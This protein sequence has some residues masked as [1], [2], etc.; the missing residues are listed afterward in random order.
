MNAFLQLLDKMKDMDIVKFFSRFFTQATLSPWLHRLQ[1]A[2]AG[3]DYS[4]SAKHL[5]LWAAI[6]AV[7][8]FVIDQVF[9][10]THPTQR[11]LTRRRWRAI[12]DGVGALGVST[13]TLFGRAR[14]MWINRDR[15]RRRP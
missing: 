13:R 11:E 4:A 2:T 6:I 7:G 3:G 12:E 1:G 10:L 5:L 8:I 14:S 15:P 9:Y